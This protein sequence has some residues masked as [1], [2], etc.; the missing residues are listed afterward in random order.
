MSDKSGKRSWLIYGTG[1]VASQALERAMSAGLSV[2]VGGRDPE[3]VG[4]L[5]KEMG[6]QHRVAN[7]HDDLRALTQGFAGVINFAGPYHETAGPLMSACIDVK[8]HYVDVSNEFLAHRHA[9]SLSHRAH[10][11]GVAIVPGA[12]MGTW[13]G[14]RLMHALV[15]KLGGTPASATLMTLPSGSKQK[16]AG[17]SASHNAVLSDPGVVIRGGLEHQ[18]H[19][20]A[21]VQELPKW[22][23]HDSGVVIG[24]GDLMALSHSLG[25]PDISSLAAVTENPRRLK[26]AFPTLVSE[27][28]RA[29]TYGSATPFQHVASGGKEAD[30]VHARLLAETT[31]YDGR[32]VRG[33]LLAGSG[34]AV[35]AEVALAT[36]LAISS[37]RLAG[38]HTVFQVLGQDLHTEK[39][40]PLIEFIC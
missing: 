35:A 18:V 24:T 28:R 19:G 22:A 13:Y 7:L 38:T 33:R 36:A 6:V 5:A 10:D 29:A 31:S 27:A 2:V 8:A 23:G 14:E 15:T 32:S 3:R 4:S 40:S 9:W 17:A 1:A 34:T 21:R 26:I 20:D 39:A 16:S 30:R 25:I 12:G 11:R 37:R